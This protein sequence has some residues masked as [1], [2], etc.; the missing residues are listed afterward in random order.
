MYRL[1][2]W[3]LPMI[4]ICDSSAV[5]NCIAL[6]VV[7]IIIIIIIIIINYY[8]CLF[9]CPSFSSL[10]GLLPKCQRILF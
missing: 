9:L 5:C 6:S 3:L 1:T 4:N 8:Y 10:L 7:S 2:P